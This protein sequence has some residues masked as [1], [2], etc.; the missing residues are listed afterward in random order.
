[1]R[2]SS[3]AGENVLDLF[4]GS[5]STLIGAEQTGR[6]TFLKELPPLYCGVIVNRWEQF[7]GRQAEL[8]RRLNSGPLGP[9][10]RFPTL[11]LEVNIDKA[12]RSLALIRDGVLLPAE[13]KASALSHKMFDQGDAAAVQTQLTKRGERGSILETL[14]DATKQIRERLGNISPSLTTTIGRSANSSSPC[15]RTWGWRR[16]SLVL[17]PEL[18]TKSPGKLHHESIAHSPLRACLVSHRVRRN[19]ERD[20]PCPDS[21]WRE[22]LSR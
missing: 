3:R 22:R 19:Q 15:C 14:L 21:R 8:V 4:G 10:T 13:D 9:V 16:Q 18:S 1:M 11:D 5:G 20:R 17:V 2:L 6:R 12:N 7:T